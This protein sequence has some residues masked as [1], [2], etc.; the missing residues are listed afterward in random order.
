MRLAIEEEE[1]RKVE[2]AEAEIALKAAQ[3]AE[4][5]ARYAARKERQKKK[6]R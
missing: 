4:R 2:A 5:D 6:K 1:R 3:K